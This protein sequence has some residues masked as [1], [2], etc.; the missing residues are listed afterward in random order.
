MLIDKLATGGTERQVIEMLKGLRKTGRFR[1]KLAVLDRGGALEGEAA[2]LAGEM[3]PVRRG[4]RFDVTPCFYLAW[5]ARSARFDL[6][7]AFGWKASLVG[8]LAARCGGVPVINGS[9]RSA[10]T[11]LLTHHRLSRLCAVRSDAIVANSQACLEAWG[12]L[13]S[14]KARVIH[15]GFDFGRLDHW[16][17]DCADQPTVCMVANFRPEKDHR[18]VLLAMEKVREREPL[19]RL[20]FVGYDGGTLSSATRLAAQ[21]GLAGSVNFVIG[22]NDPRP[23][24]SISQVCVLASTNGEGISNAILEYMYFRKPVVATDVGGNREVIDNEITG[25][26]V[27]CGQPDVMADRILILLRERDRAR[28]MG[29]AGRARVIARFSLDRMIAEYEQLYADVLR[30]RP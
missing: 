10:P 21:I 28:R 25:F 1:T 19:A 6:I 20:V 8:L 17:G 16:H 22:T 4:W 27:P 3:L 5:Q 13:G 12:L 2:E 14:P 15:N 30:L 9:V 26:L 24:I 29:D 11:R 18:S 7:H 23:F